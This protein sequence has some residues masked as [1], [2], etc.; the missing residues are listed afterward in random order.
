[1]PFFVGLDMSKA[2]TSI[3]V[4]NERGERVSEGT[5]PTDPSSIISFLRGEGRRYRRVGVESTSFTPWIF[6]R[7]AKAGL[8][9]ICI[10]SRHARS[11]LKDRRVNKTDRNDA[12]GIAEIMRAGIYKTVHIKT[13]TSQEGKLVLTSRAH[14]V[15]AKRNID[16]LIRGFLLQFGLKLEAGRRM[17][18]EARARALLKGDAVVARIVRNLLN[19]RASIIAEF[20]SLDAM[21]I[22]L[23]TGD[24]I[25]RRL[26]TAPGVGPFV[27]LTFRCGVD[28]PERFTSSRTVGVHFGLTKPS[29]QSG[30]SDPDGRISRLGDRTVRSALYM[31]AQGTLRASARPTA[32]R[33]W[34]LSVRA[35]RGGGRAVVAVARRLAVILHRM[36]ISGTDFYEP[37]GAH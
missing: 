8:P 9:I 36:W 19:V 31:A 16:N 17:T 1:M 37:S 12:R 10:E 28:V 13:K 6:E 30:K 14:M 2:T 25:C 35:S 33:S 20:K 4:E 11:I 21:V 27:A 22:R 24:P 3:C 18:F 7:L 32:L 5:V 34:G 23:A 29:R 26:M 15:R